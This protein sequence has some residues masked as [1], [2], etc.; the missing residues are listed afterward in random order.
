V[1]GVVGALVIAR[2]SWALMRQTGAILLDRTDD[3]VAAQVRAMVE[4]VATITDLHVWRLGP[5][6]LA[7]IVDVAEP[8]DIASIR[9][10]LRTLKGVVHLTVQAHDLPVA[11]RAD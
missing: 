6:A 10:H 4:P 7:V 3:R 9:K 1:I 8:A 2:W 11:S 5:G